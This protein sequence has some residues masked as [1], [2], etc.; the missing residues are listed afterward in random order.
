MSVTT[1]GANGGDNQDDTVAIQKAIDAVAVQGGG[2]VTFPAGIYIVNSGPTNGFNGAIWMKSHVRLLGAGPRQSILKMPA[3]SRTDLAD[4]KGRQN[5][6]CVMIG[7]RSYVVSESSTSLVLDQTKWQEDIEIAYLGFDLD[8][9]GGRRAMQMRFATRNVR[10]HH[11]EGFQSGI[12]AGQTAQEGLTTD[13]HFFNMASYGAPID[14]GVQPNFVD[15]SENITLDDNVVRDFLQLTADGGCGVRNLWIHHNKIYD[16]QEFGIAVTFTGAINTIMEDLLIEDNEIFSPGGAGIVVWP[17]FVGNDMDLSKIQIQALRRVTIRRNKILVKPVTYAGQSSYSG[18]TS[19]GVGLG[20]FL[21]ETR[22]IHVEDNELTAENPQKLSN[23]RQAFRTTCWDL[24]W[25]QYWKHQH[26]GAPP[27]I[28]A[29]NFDSRTAIITLTGHGLATGLQIQLVP[30]NSI[31]LP[32]GIDPYRSYRFIRIDENRFSLAQLSGELVSFDRASAG[33][34]FTMMVS[35]VAENVVIANNK[36]TGVWDWDADFSIQ[37]RNLQAYDN[38]LC[39]RFVFSGSHENLRFFNNT[40]TGNLNIASSTLRDA[41]FS[42]NSWLVVDCS[43]YPNY[44][45]AIC[46]FGPAQDIWRRVE[47][48]FDSNRFSFSPTR[49]SRTIAAIGMIPSSWSGTGALSVRGNQ[50]LTPTTV[51]WNIA[52]QFL[53][54]F[55]DAPLITPS[56]VTIINPGFEAPTILGSGYN[57]FAYNPVTSGWVFQGQAGISGNQSGFTSGNPIAPE[58]NQVGFIQ[59]SGS[60]SQ[61]LFLTAGTYQLSAWA[62]QRTVWQQQAQTVLVYIDSEQIGTFM[63]KDSNY[64][65]AITR[66]FTVAKGNHSLRLVGQ[67][68]LDAT[69]F[70]DKLSLQRVFSS[71]T[72]SK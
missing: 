8:N 37:T 35:P 61:A 25:T 46:S 17:N 1:Y 71:T 2:T 57:A 20:T 66:T 69:I 52:P 21:T 9:G 10:I 5:R 33:G 45:G 56:V 60:I 15:I 23:S 19:V 55:S 53:N 72:R 34:N 65:P 64:Q 29:R 18:R 42:G 13:N 44:A 24:N 58:G 50:V 7:D 70:L 12:E 59:Q 54:D 68:S 30:L 36:I 38:L 26:N 43:D 48:T 63:P 27:T 4:R 14:R 11:C 32:A 3:G 16:P 28:P 41:R 6:S 62:A 47:A 51:N 49:Y 40:S 22:D 31:A 39:S 67:A